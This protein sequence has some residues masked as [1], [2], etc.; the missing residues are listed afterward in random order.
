MR[1]N[2]SRSSG[3]SSEASIC[4]C[5][6]LVSLMA[7][8]VAGAKYSIS[9]A[10]HPGAGVAHPVGR[11]ALDLQAVLQHVFH[12]GAQRAQLPDGHRAAEQRQA[13]DAGQ[14]QRQ[15]A[16]DGALAG[17]QD[18]RHAK[19]PRTACGLRRP[20]LLQSPPCSRVRRLSDSHHP[21]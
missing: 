7:A 2:S 19:T 3:V 12:L 15:P 16:A 6:S 5:S 14:H 21:V 18:G 13:E 9:D 20:H 1:A 11:G 4:F 17:G 8:A 10:L